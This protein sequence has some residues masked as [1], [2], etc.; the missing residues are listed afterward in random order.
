VSGGQSFG[1]VT[2]SATNSTAVTLHTLLLDASDPFGTLLTQ[3]VVD[4]RVPQTVVSGTVA[5]CGAKVSYVRAPA[6]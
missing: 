4:I 5:Y 1:T 2:T 3:M 6:G